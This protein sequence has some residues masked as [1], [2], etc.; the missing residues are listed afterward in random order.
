[1]LDHQQMKEKRRQDRATRRKVRMGKPAAAADRLSSPQPTA[2]AD[3]FPDFSSPQTA[4]AGTPPHCGVV[5]L[6]Q[7]SQK[8]TRK[9]KQPIS[10]EQPAPKKART[11]EAEVEE[12]VGVSVVLVAQQLNRG[13]SDLPLDPAELDKLATVVRKVEKEKTLYQIRAKNQVMG[14]VTVGKF[15]NG[16]KASAA[17]LRLLAACGSSKAEIAAAKTQLLEA[18]LAAD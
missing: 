12:F 15:G 8:K 3:R 1:M 18:V 2:A 6:E 10:T 17:I 11:S 7:Q 4:A 9:S 14:Q 16:A 5:E 13:V